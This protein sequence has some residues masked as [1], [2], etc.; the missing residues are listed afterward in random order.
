MPT[1]QISHGY[2][3]L[4]P[5][6]E[7]IAGSYGS[8]KLTYV[9]GTKGVAPGGRIRVHTESDTDWG[10]PQLDDPTGADYLTATAPAGVRIDLLVK[11]ARALTA[12]VAGRGLEPGEQFALTYGD[13]QGG[14]PGSR[15]QTF[16]EARHFFW[17][18]VDIDGNGRY[19]C[20]PDP[21]E[22]KIIGAAPARL[23][24][25]APSTVRPDTRSLRLQV[26]VEDQWGNPTAFQGTVD[27]A[28]PD[29]ELPETRIAFGPEDG[30]VRWLEG[31]RC[32]PGTHRI[33]A[34]AAEAELEAASNPILCA[35]SDDPH[36]LFWGDFHGGQVA[37]AE[38]ITDFFAYARDVAA[39]H[40]AGYQRNDHFVTKEDWAIQQQA[41]RAGDEPGHFVAIP[42]FEWSPNTSLGGHHNVFFR[43]HGQSI[44][45]AGRTDIGDEDVDTDLP[46]I[47]DLYRA[48]RNTDTV[49][50]PHVGGQHSNLDYHDPT[51]EPAIE[52]TSTHGSFEWIIEEVMQRGYRLGFLGGSDSH[53]G[54][55]G[56]D[57]PGYQPRRYAKAGLTGLY[58]TECSLAAF[59][60]A[61]KARRC[62]ATT[63]A[64]IAMAVH[65]DGRPMGAE[66]TTS[67]PP[68]I[69]AAITGTGPLESVE[70]FRGLERLYNHPLPAAQT[71]RRVRLLWEGASRKSSYSGVVWDGGLRVV[72]GAIQ[73]V[74]T[75]RFDS[76]R[77][78]VTEQETDQL[79]WHAISCGYRSGLLLELDGDNPVLHF[80]I[81]T[82][83]IVGPGPTV[84]QGPALLSESRGEKLSF[85]A[86][87]AELAKGPKVL[88]LGFLDR[89]ITLSLDREPS[90]EQAEFE[91]AD[92]APEPGTNPYWLRVVQRDMEMAWSSP[93]FVDYAA[94]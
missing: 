62:Y 28:A 77:C 76:P 58:A 87:L 17:V 94:S 49:I 36:D 26:R 59:L 55:P 13:Q 10:M 51:L 18:D 83:L 27:L 79:R 65:A 84:E 4:T 33:V 75:I 22:L 30:G 39:I 46:H 21:P 7:V 16:C 32:N 41:E 19:I 67:T 68:L 34:S 82:A 23:V 50:T 38:K 90:A 92:S 70:L 91:F 57:R 64:R 69:S 14:G 2:A 60:D 11:D 43:R 3:R 45:R 12:I 40:F 37:M 6:D 24:V 80:S 78:R 63:G 73:T 53:T 56:A 20:L 86:D 31:G 74:S 9:A 81:D 42:G 61:L 89:R 35:A 93:I 25:V 1:E 44:R 47:T 66:Y 5:D 8:W 15:A 52:I 85:S 54:R 29:I 48:Y 72:N 88:E 71:A